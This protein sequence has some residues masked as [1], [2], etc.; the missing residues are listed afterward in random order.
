MCFSLLTAGWAADPHRPA[1]VHV[2]VAHGGADGLAG[3]LAHPPDPARYQVLGDAA[4]L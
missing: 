2:G 1:V 3:H 4:H